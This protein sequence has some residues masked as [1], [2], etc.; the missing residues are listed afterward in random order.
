MQRC[1]VIGGGFSGSGEEFGLMRIRTPRAER[2][3]EELH[4]MP[5]SIN[6][7]GEVGIL[8]LPPPPAPPPPLV[9]EAALR[10][11]KRLEEEEADRAMKE[12]ARKRQYQEE[13]ERQVRFRLE[14]KERRREEE[15]SENLAALFNRLGSKWGTIQ[16]E[17]IEARRREIALAKFEMQKHERRR[18]ERAATTIQS[19]W[20]GV[21]ER[22]ETRVIIARHRKKLMEERFSR[23]MVKRRKKAALHIQRIWWGWR[24]RLKY[25]E[26]RAMKWEDWLARRIRKNLF[27]LSMQASEKDALKK[28]QQQANKNTRK[29]IYSTRAAVRLQSWYRGW[30]ARQQAK[31]ARLLQMK[32]DSEI[33]SDMERL[34]RIQR[35][36]LHTSTELTDHK[37]MTK[38]SR[39]LKRRE[40]EDHERL[41]G[42]LRKVRDAARAVEAD[43]QRDSELD[44]VPLRELNDFL[45][46]KQLRADRDRVREEAD[47]AILRRASGTEALR[48]AMEREQ[49]LQERLDAKEHTIDFGRLRFE[50]RQIQKDM[51][52]LNDGASVF[53]RLEDFKRELDLAT[54]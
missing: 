48:A 51:A 31:R 40:I 41:T 53:G 49:R 8:R 7:W 20:R 11:K 34:R 18:R 12:A 30:K 16:E 29:L 47:E 42:D 45:E 46:A 5:C 43:L 23:Y 50:A 1:V 38:V 14:E 54:F 25:R 44:V 24:G 22:R 39:A 19:W 9:D 28:R 35:E 3:A 33:V 13:L 17:K 27:W 10:R 26:V 4:A 37:D 15:N 21:I 2:D 6:P 32:L 36:A 52:E